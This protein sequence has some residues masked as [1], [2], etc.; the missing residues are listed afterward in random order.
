M[1]VANPPSVANPLVANPHPNLSV[2]TNLV[3]QTM[4]KR[5]KTLKL[6]LKANKVYLL[7]NIFSSHLAVSLQV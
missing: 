7:S 2:V 5:K 3:G 6:M 1:P 4:L